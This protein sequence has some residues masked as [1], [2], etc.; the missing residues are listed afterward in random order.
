MATPWITIEQETL[1]LI[2]ALL[3]DDVTGAETN[4]RAIPKTATQIDHPGFHPTFV[5]ESI[6]DAVMLI[7]GWVCASEG[8]PQAAQFR[9]QASV[10]HGGLL[11]VSMGPYGP[12]RDTGTGRILAQRANPAE[13]TAIVDDITD[14]GGAVAYIYAIDGATLYCS[15]TPAQVTYTYYDRPA[16]TVAQVD[17][18]FTSTATVLPLGDQFATPVKLL[19][20]HC[21][22]MKKGAML[23]I[24]GAAGA[25]AIDALTALSVR[26]PKG[27]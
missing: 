27:M 22:A 23:D 14:L 20:L 15:P 25:A 2:N 11:P 9:Q 10:A 7:V 24:S 19:A 3:T 6:I 26:A 16:A 5:R 8:H 1:A 17:A 18:L 21:L 4:Y 12:V 13:V